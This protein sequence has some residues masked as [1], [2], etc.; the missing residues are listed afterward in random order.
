MAKDSNCRMDEV[1]Q[2]AKEVR[3]AKEEQTYQ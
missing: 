3:A 1:A 2:R